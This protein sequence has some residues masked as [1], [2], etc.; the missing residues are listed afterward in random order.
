MGKWI[1]A[2]LNV[3][4][5]TRI[6]TPVTR[7][8]YPSSNQLR[9]LPTPPLREDWIYIEEDSYNYLTSWLGKWF[10]HERSNRPYIIFVS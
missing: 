2:Q 8:T 9:Y 1:A 6:H 5:P 4:A 10:W 7:V 3:K